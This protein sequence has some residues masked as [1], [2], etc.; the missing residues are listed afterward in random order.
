MFRLLDVL[1]G[2]LLVLGA[3]VLPAGVHAR[4]R[5][6]RQQDQAEARGCDAAYHL[7]DTWISVAGAPVQAT[8]PALNLPPCFRS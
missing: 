3:L 4:Q 8:S 5:D 7:N 2:L 6:Q 1:L